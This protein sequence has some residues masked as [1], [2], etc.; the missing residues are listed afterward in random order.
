MF[1]KSVSSLPV[2][3]RSGSN[4]CTKT[5]LIFFRIHGEL[6]MEKSTVV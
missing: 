1:L 4:H 6:Q 3:I 2:G 5:D